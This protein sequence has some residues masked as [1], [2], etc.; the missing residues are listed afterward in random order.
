[1]PARRLTLALVCVAG[2][3]IYLPTA[4]FTFV[5]DDRA[6]V[7]ANPRAHS[8]SQALRAFDEPYWPTPS[9]GEYY[10]PLTILSYAVDWTLSGG[11]AG[12]LHLMNALWHGLASLLV[13][14]V[15]ERWLSPAAAVAGGLIF[16]LHPVHVEAV[17]GLVGRAEVLAAA[18]ML[19][20]VLCARRGWWV[21]TV[22]CAAA[23]MLSKEHGVTTGVLIVLDRWLRPTD[24]PRYPAGLYAAL[25][26]VTAAFVVA[27]YLIG[28]RATSDVAPVFL[29]AGTGQRLVIALPAVLRAA[30][31]LGWP[32]DL[33]ADYGPQV[34]PAYSAISVAA[35]GGTVVVGAAVATGWW[36]RRAAPALSFGAWASVATYLPTSNL[37]FPSGIVL[38]ERNLYLPVLLV[39]A[40]TGV[41]V[42]WVQG[43]WGGAAPRG[44]GIVTAALAVALGW[45]TL[46][47]LPV[48]RDNRTFLLTLLTEHP[49]SYRGHW[50]AAAVLA[51]LGDTAGARRE[52]AGADSLF[53][54]DPHL[55]ATHALFLL[56]LRDT[57][58]ARP[59]V[60]RARQRVAYEPIALRAQ[61]LLLLLRGQRAGATALAD[62]ARIRAPWDASWYD[63]Q[64]R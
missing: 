39:A 18:G 59:L 20:A 50:S 3:A 8:V 29:G 19:G 17:A 5:Q 31:L 28:H 15:F 47:R 62:T 12:W 21:A 26:G 32:V 33:S 14:L 37:A 64:L 7:A 38:A 4:Q 2:T 46:S 36:A 34:I 30:G 24:E 9:G 25:G 6:I 57:A 23:A 27:W 35:L 48:W 11:R 55:D 43:R 52:Y 41:A 63:V 53:H 42:Q 44:I 54:G 13:V 58:G 51:G 45:R 56:G 16:A 22:A 61:V 10:R 40:L 49:E 60:E 1:M